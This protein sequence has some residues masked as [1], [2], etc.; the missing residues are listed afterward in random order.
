MQE[1]AQSNGP[2]GESEVERLARE[3]AELRRE[4][5][6]LRAGEAGAASPCFILNEDNTGTGDGTALESPVVDGPAFAVRNSDPNSDLRS[7]A[8]EGQGGSVG[9]N[10]FGIYVGVQ[11]YAPTGYAFHAY[12]PNE[13]NLAGAHLILDPGN[14]AGAPTGGSHSA[15][16][17]WMDQ[18]AVLWQ[19]MAS[20][21]PGAWVSLSTGNFVPL[22]APVRCYD[23]RPGEPPT[24]VTKGA[25]STGQTRTIDL[26]HN[27]TGVPTTASAILTNVTIV[28]TVGGGFLSMFSAGV[29]WPGTT[30]I[31]WFGSSQVLS[32]NA[33]SAFQGSGSAANVSVLCGGTGSTDFIIDVLGYYV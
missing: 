4:V 8:I 15:G 32:N 17:L 21:T 22:A 9:V 31:T 2:S 11:G 33:T 23:S 3:V 20:G 16:E 14:F 19:C 10:A 28:D 12:G 7:T 30:S 6:S 18:Q 24:D 26:T 27:S 25:L 1:I 29:T 5:Q 13:A